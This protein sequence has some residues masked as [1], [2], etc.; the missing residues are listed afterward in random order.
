M[1]GLEIMNEVKLKLF[2]FTFSIMLYSFCGIQQAFSQKVSTC[3]NKKV[4]EVLSLLCDIDTKYNETGEYRVESIGT[5]MPVIVVADAS[6]VINHAGIKLFD[7]RIM[8]ENP[9]PVYLF[10]ERYL[11]WVLLTKNNE[12]IRTRLSEER[13][14]FRFGSSTEG[15]ICRNLKR[16]LALI[17]PGQSMIITTDNSKYS[18]SWVKDQSN[19]L[20]VSFPIQYELIWGMNKKEAENQF[21]D[22]LKS[23]KFDLKMSSASIPDHLIQIN[24]SCYR[25]DG[26]FYGLEQITSYQYFKKKPDG[27]YALMSDKFNPA[28]SVANLFTA[29]SPGAI[30]ADIT[31]RLYGGRK[32]T[33]SVS[34]AQLKGFCKSAGSEVYVGI[35]KQE[36]NHILGT[37]MMVNRAL[38]YNHI[39]YFDV[40]VRVFI[41]P[42]RFP[43][44]IQLYS[45]VPMHNVSNLFDDKK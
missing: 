24:D 5:E 37:A 45:Y 41:Y 2:V 10:V 3:S 1:L 16:S 13:V 42:E 43:V 21:Y 38:G 32:D 18:I 25:S 7:R 19:V 15:D 4:A 29:E 44:K 12:T 22:E 31:H 11:L 28:E 9:S 39:L 17:R 23:S 26:D 30:Q 20:S 6:G 36:V 14:R 34:L 27:S 35:E 40:D 8:R 33:F